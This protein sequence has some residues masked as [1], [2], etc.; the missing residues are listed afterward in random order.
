MT[1][2]LV[3]GGDSM[4]MT[5]LYCIYC[6]EQCASSAILCNHIILNH[7]KDAYQCPI[8]PYRSGPWQTFNH[9][10]HEHAT[11]EETTVLV[12][13]HGDLNNDNILQEAVTAREFKINTCFNFNDKYMYATFF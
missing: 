2:H 6:L 1:M 13:L 3:D 9:L 7:K 8:C 12:T 11:D 10:R 5:N 4:K